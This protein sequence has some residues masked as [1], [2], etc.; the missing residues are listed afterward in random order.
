MP[1]ASRETTSRRIGDH[2]EPVQAELVQAELVQAELVQA[3]LVQAE[4]PRAEYPRP[5][6][7]RQEWLNLNGPWRFDEGGSAQVPSSWSL[8][9]TIVVPFA[10]ESELSGIGRTDFVDA[11][12]YQREVTLPEEWRGQ[13]VLLHV[14]AADHHTTVWVDDVEVGRHRGGFTSFSVDLTDALT[15][16]TFTLSLLVEDDRHAVQARGKQSRRAE[17]YEAFYTRTTGIWQTVWLEPVP[18]SHL[19]RPVTVPDLASSSFAFELP[20]ARPHAGLTARVELSDDGGL[21]AAGAVEVTSRITPGLTLDVPAD[22]LRLWSPEDPHLYR[23]RFTLLDDGVP[24]DTLDSYAG[25]R[26]VAID[27][28]RMLLN[29]RPV[30]QRLVLDQGYWPDGLLTAPSDADLVR[31]IEL[32]RA[33]GFNGARLHQKVFEERYLYH[34][35]RL[36]YLVWGEFADWGAL[37]DDG[38]QVPT[39]SFV[40][41][42]V[43]ALTRDLSHPSIVGW[44]PLNETFEPIG[45]RLSV[46]D[47]AT[48]ALYLLTKAVD[49]TRPVLDTSGYAHRV[50]GADVYD[51]HLYEQDPAVFARQMDGLAAGRPYTNRAPDGSPWSVPYAGQ[52]YFCS[53]FGGIWWSEVD[54]HGDDS[55]GYG[56]APRSAPEWV[57]RFRALVDRLLDDPDMFGYCFTQLTD[58]FQEKNGIAR[59]DRV[60]KFDLGLLR[61][62]Q[63]RPAAI[64]HGDDRPA[65]PLT[66]RTAPAPHP[67]DAARTA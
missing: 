21:V 53:E 24:V 49:P 23:V 44:C 5:Q 66:A 34:A 45:P 28:R 17:N 35:D 26:S 42:W 48:R 55:W 16:P 9:G 33:A 14:G 40:T 57:D 63:T 4:L 51:S 50:P 60:P 58:V 67:A 7:V 11:V 41:E 22:R 18:A 64:E 47:D 61:S 8:A 36:G 30:F 20:V 15:G 32:G 56:E 6:L 19:L 43:E 31:D 1:F 38:R 3:E 13:R 25:M 37:D 52:P 62:I 39:V 65:G 10:R 2:A 29:G 12:R 46:L 54:G 59:F 27:G